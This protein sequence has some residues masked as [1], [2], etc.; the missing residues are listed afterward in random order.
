MNVLETANDIL[1]KLI[2]GTPIAEKK[3]T[4]VTT[5]MRLVGEPWLTAF[6]VSVEEGIPPTRAYC[7]AGIV[8][9]SYEEVT[10]ISTVTDCSSSI[11]WDANDF[12]IEWYDINEKHIYTFNGKKNTFK[13]FD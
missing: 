3:P 13:Q 5:A 6:A 1:S 8:A 12:D 7:I 10:G 2:A 11:G 9:H 4:K